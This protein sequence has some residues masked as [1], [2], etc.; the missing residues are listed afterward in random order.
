VQKV[1]QISNTII[2][3]L[4]GAGPWLEIIDGIALM[5]GLGTRFFA[6]SLLIL[7]IG[8]SSP[9]SMPLALH[10]PPDEGLLA[11]QWQT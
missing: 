9:Q 3:L 7:T 11:A 1:V 8:F 4:N 10:H 5:V 6:F 2:G